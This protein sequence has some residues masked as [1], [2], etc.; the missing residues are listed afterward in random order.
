MT[1]ASSEAIAPA[2]VSADGSALAD[3]P[4]VAIGAD[5]L[6]VVS[7]LL[8][9]V[10]LASLGAVLGTRR[11][12]RAVARAARAD[13]HGMHDLLRTV[14]MAETMSGIGV[15]QYDPT[16]G[17]QQWSQGMRH[18]FGV[19]GDEAFV[20]GDA[21]T[22]LLASGI[23]LVA[24]VAWRS[25]ATA[26][27][28]LQ[29]EYVDLVAG[30]RSLRVQAC[31]LRGE[32]GCVQRVVAVLR[33]VTDQVARERALET[34]RARAVGE[35]ERVRVLADT[36]PLTG[37]ANRRRIMAELDRLVID[38]REGGE[39]VMLVMFDIDHFKQV[40]DRHGHLQGDLVLQQVARIAGDEARAGDLVGRVGGE[41]FVWIVAGEPRRSIDSMTENLRQAVS[42]HSGT[43]QIRPVT[44]SLGYATARPGD[45]SLSL[46]ARADQ[47]LYAAKNAGR[48][49]ICM[50]A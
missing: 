14:R 25:T 12:A 50:A 9:V 21:E 3:I 17:I 5:A 28:E 24:Q 46:F 11:R 35:A 31:N 26:P 42:Q 18:L 29:F 39:A 36:D 44:I 15:W 10:A 47:A 1:G 20:E 27:F 45:T 33:D 30:A 41:E 34:S 16:T 37:L 22:L 48:N 4:G 2:F 38:A 7:V 6:L 8:L 32:D 23:D 43:A 13:S 49:R 40:N 19:D